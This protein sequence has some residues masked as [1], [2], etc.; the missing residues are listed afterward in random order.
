[1]TYA[2]RYCQYVFG[3]PTS[4]QEHEIVAHQDSRRAAAIE[5]RV[6]GHGEGQMHAIEDVNAGRI[7]DLIAPAPEDQP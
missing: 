4:R 2:C 3:G 6:V 5:A 1:M 7:D